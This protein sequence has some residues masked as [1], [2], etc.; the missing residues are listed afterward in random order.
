MDSKK[1]IGMDVHK[2]SISIAVRNDVGKIVMECVIETKANIILDFIHGLRGELHVTFEEGTWAAWLYDLLKPHVTELV[3]CDPRKN[4]SMREGNQ[5]DKIDAL[6]LAELLRLNHLS[7]VYHGEHGLRRLKELV[8]S[9]LTITKDL[10]RVMTRVKA[11]YRSWGIPCTGKQVYA[12][13][14]R[15]E[16]LGKIGEPGVRR[17]A[18]FYYQQLDALRTL[19]QEVRRDLLAESKK[20]QAWKRLCEIPSIGPIRAA[21]LLGI[22][23]TP[24]RFRTKRQL[25]TYG[26]VGIETSSSAD[27]HG[28]KGQLERKKKQVEI[29][30]LNRNYNHDLK[31]LFK[32]AAIVAATKPGP[33]AEFY[34]E[35]LAKG[36]RQG[37]GAADP[38]QEDCHDRSDRVEERSVLRRPTSET[39][40]S[41]SVS[42][43]V[44]SILGIFSGG[45]RGVLETLGFESESQLIS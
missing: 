11:I 45:G 32:G 39:T 26:G 22:L 27:H 36:M 38:G 35:L 16:W 28:L 23:Q 18:E 5:S 40:N 8:R 42:D 37:N 31:N 17:R 15:A 3:V 4:A 19:R 33:F 24:H 2:E 10:G 30:G 34:S 25:W 14:H 20:H 29:R 13:R 21:V 43:R 41:L 9:Y 1:Y 44:R 7:P 12:P 6:R